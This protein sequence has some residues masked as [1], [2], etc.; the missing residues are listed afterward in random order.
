[1]STEYKIYLVNESASTK[2][3]WCFL[4]KPEGLTGP[5]VFA[6]S[7]SSLSVTPNY[8]GTNL[9]TVPLQYSLQAGASNEAVG[10]DIRIDSTISVNA[11]LKKKYQADYVTAPPKQGP[12]LTLDQ[13]GSSPAKTMAFK[14]NGFNKVQNE[15]N[16]WFS[17]ATFGIETGNG[18]MG[19]TWSPDP[20][21]TKT[22]TPKFEFYIATG[23]FE[24]NKLADFNTISNDSAIIPLS[25]FKNLEATVTLTETGSWVVTAGR[26]ELAMA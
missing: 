4:T 2:N 22:I 8:A 21:D 26:P 20:N 14:T 5:N 24:S 3:M 7:S 6:N 11:D 13:T 19:V 16:Q 10:L 9:F 1:M 17:S 23:S 15:D 18:F 25:M 12:N